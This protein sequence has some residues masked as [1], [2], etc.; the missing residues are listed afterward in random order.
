M[1]KRYP[2]GSSVRGCIDVRQAESPTAT[3]AGGP[4]PR[5]SPAASADG[6]LRRRDRALKM[7]A[8]LG[9]SLRPMRSPTRSKICS[10]PAINRRRNAH[11]SLW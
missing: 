3:A 9:A 5:H 11:R 8:A 7:P 2:T 4:D 1:H 6:A 10:T